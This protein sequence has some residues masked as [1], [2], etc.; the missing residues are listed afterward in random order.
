M[1]IL[2]SDGAGLS[3]RQTA[4]ALH[5]SGH[6][7]EVLS[8]D[9]LSLT[10]FTRHVKQLH[11]APRL[12]ADP[13]AWL[14]RACD[15]L[16]RGRF[17]VLL[18]TQEHVAVLARFP[19]RV[20]DMGVAMAVPPFAALARVQD[21]VSAARTLQE[22]DIPQPGYQVVYSREELEAVDPPSYVKVA[23]G[24][25]SSGVYAVTDRDQLATV[26]TA[27]DETGA[28][29]DGVLV[30]EPADGAVVM[31]QA[32]FDR[33]DLVAV[34]AAWRARDGYRG[35]AASKV[36]ADP[37]AAREY[38]GTLGRALGWHG[39]LAADAIL[40]TGGHRFI[41]INPRLIEPM[42]AA[43]AGL[44]VTAAMLAVSTGQPFQPARARVS[45]KT[46]Q[47]I[48]G[49]LSA[50]RRRAVLRELA[51][52]LGGRGPYFM[53][54]EELTPLR[55]DTR[56]LLPVGVVAVAMVA[57]PRLAARF[58]SNSVGSYSLTP[59]AWRQLREYP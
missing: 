58:G 52:A 28:F 51:L 53:S 40:H 39:A 59:E 49:L 4:T 35:G 48:Q 21:K 36:S 3:G 11:H 42:N 29:R 26:A 7:V 5:R 32:V 33:G 45:V 43:L 56:T 10:R 6:H 25:A 50:T 38:L 46:H 57:Q 27:L 18:P 1:R 44:D 37:G 34:H 31:L 9:P 24:T 55:G 14:D 23:I 13:I 22:L 12:G 47:L 30:Q 41:D 16:A 2:L 15:V 19:E 8:S 54:T 20:L 17:D